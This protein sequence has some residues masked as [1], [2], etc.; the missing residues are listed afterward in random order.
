MALKMNKACTLKV[1]QIEKNPILALG[2]TKKHIEK[3]GRVAKAYGNVAPA[4][5]SQSANG[6]R[7]LAGQAGLIAC[8]QNGI[9]E[10]PAIVTETGGDV[11]QMKLALLLS[12]VR[13]EGGSLSEGALIDELT[14]QHGVTRR[15]LMLLLNKSKSWISKRQSMAMRL[16]AQVKEMVRNGSVSSRTAEE[17]AKL[18]QDVQLSFACKVAMDGINKTH[19]GK[20]VSMYKAEDTSGALREAIL[21]APLTVLDATADN[22]YRITRRKEKR[23]VAER[24]VGAAGVVIRLAYELKR[25]LAAADEQSISKLATDLTALR[26]AMVDLNATLNLRLGVSPGKPEGCD[27]L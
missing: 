2:V 9:R 22:S 25:L 23:G 8:A 19:A 21:A 18:P 13:E 15:E 20:L 3:Y 14:A 1:G 10:M 5:V 16:T 27:T 11:E 26:G 17:I 7:I 24:I 6:Y 12:T 4:I